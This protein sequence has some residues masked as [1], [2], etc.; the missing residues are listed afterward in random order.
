MALL[1]FLSVNSDQMLWFSRNTL[2]RGVWPPYTR[3]G[4]GHEFQMHPL[5]Y[6]NGFSLGPLFPPGTL[7]CEQLHRGLAFLPMICRWD[8]FFIEVLHDH[9]ELSLS[10]CCYPW[11]TQ[12]RFKKV[13]IGQNQC[14]Y[15]TLTVFTSSSSSPVNRLNI[16]PNNPSVVPLS[17]PTPSCLGA[18]LFT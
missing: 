10:F 3:T 12:F 6:L 9:K 11:N 8:Q 16:R 14:I 1:V 15:T 7:L 17:K 13:H 18:V 4:I 5:S 2:M